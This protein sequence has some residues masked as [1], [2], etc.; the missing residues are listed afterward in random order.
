[1]NS[2]EI[3]EL[4]KSLGLSQYKFAVK[5]GMTVKAISRWENNKSKPSPLAIEKLEKL[6]KSTKKIKSGDA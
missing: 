4:R 2:E 3:K 5:L 1:M 6:Q